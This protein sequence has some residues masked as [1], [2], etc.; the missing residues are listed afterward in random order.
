MFADDSCKIDVNHD[1][2]GNVIMVMTMWMTM[3]T[4]TT[5]LTVMMRMMTSLSMA[6]M[7]MLFAMALDDADDDK[8]GCRCPQHLNAFVL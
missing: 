8:H 3:T 4:M 2:E 7:I 1:E 6:T 5:V